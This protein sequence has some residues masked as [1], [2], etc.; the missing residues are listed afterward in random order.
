MIVLLLPP[1]PHLHMP[2]SIHGNTLDFSLQLICFIFLL[3][4]PALKG[5]LNVL[6]SCAKSPSLK[7]VVL[8]SSVAAVAYNGKPRTPDVVVDET[9]FTDADFCAK[10]NEL[11]ITVE[12]LSKCKREEPPKHQVPTIDAGDDNS[13]F[14]EALY[15]S[16]GIGF[17]TSFVGFIGSILLL[18]SWRETYSKF[19]NTL[20][21]RIIIWW[22]Q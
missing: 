15:M 21:L 6:N 10:S 22:K 18:P 8:T 11:N 17:F 4:D 12:M 16:M 14:L 20:I 5:T 19:L 13:V 7:R 2:V 1:H 9:W 3:I